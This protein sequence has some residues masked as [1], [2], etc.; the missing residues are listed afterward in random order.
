[1]ACV[2]HALWQI[3]K[4]RNELIFEHRIYTLQWSVAVPRRAISATAF[5]FTG[6]IRNDQRET[7][8][9][10]FFN[11]KSKFTGP[12]MIKEVHWLKPQ[13]GWT[14]V[15]FNGAALGQ[16]GKASCGGV[17]RMY[18]GYPRGCFAI[19]LGIQTPIFTELMGFIV[20][21]ELA[22]TKDWSHYG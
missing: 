16:P 10:R 20:V 7:A 3:W 21:D 15:N 12:T 13:P 2:L 19:P 11:V 9:C 18:I 14:K 22:E 4:I 5:M 17:F 8:I 1:M 6:K